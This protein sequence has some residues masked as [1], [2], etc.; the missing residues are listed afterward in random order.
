MT[1][2]ALDRSYRVYGI[3]ARFTLGDAV[4]LYTIRQ[5]KPPSRLIIAADAGPTPDAVDGVPVVR[6]D[7]GRVK[8]GDCWAVAP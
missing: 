4:S 7:T 3:S 5:G 6:D 1:G 8:R 2:P